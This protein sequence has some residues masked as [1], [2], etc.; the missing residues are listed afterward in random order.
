MNRYTLYLIA[1]G[2]SRADTPVLI[3]NRVVSASSFPRRALGLIGRRSIEPDA[4][5][6]LKPG[7][8]IHTFGMR[9]TIDVLFLNRQLHILAAHGGVR[10]RRVVWAPR[11]TASTLEL[12]AGPIR[13]HRLA[14]G[15]RLAI[16][17]SEDA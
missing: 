8:S 12:A 2:A 6:W 3:A 1:H 13:R 10:P 15:D 5:L 17:E 11:A 4:A 16:R 14:A 9:F 7:G